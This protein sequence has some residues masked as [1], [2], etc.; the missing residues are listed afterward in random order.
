MT[1]GDHRLFNMQ[2]AEAL[3]CVFW[4]N[5]NRWL[6]PPARMLQPYAEERM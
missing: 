2:R 5:C 1:K 4:A 3:C 6:Q